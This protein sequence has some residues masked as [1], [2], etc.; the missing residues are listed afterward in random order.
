MSEAESGPSAGLLNDL[1]GKDKSKPKQLA[2]HQQSHTDKTR[3]KEKN[4]ISIP[5][6]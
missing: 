4:K 1:M 6:A 3:Q 5:G 2:E